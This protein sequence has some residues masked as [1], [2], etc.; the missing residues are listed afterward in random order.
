MDRI[1]VAVV[2]GATAIVLG[3]GSGFE[4]AA[5]KLADASALSVAALI[6]QACAFSLL[7]A[8]RKA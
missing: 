2:C 8:F 7:L 5:G 4:E 3:R 6:F 1:I